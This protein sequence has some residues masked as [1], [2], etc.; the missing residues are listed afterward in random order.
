MLNPEGLTWK[1]WYAAAT[2]FHGGKIK[3]VSLD[4]QMEHIEVLHKAWREGEDPT[5]YA[6]IDYPLMRR[7]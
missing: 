3:F 7:E 2:C 1:E 4:Q 5:E 6:N